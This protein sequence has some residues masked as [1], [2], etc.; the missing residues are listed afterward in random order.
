MNN[1]LLRLLRVRPSWADFLRSV[2]SPV[3]VAQGRIAGVVSSAE[4]WVVAVFRES[5]RASLMRECRPD[6]PVSP[7]DRIR[8]GPRSIRSP[9]CVHDANHSRTRG[10]QSPGHLLTEAFV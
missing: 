2:Y 7:S 4:A 1:R 10:L 8:A 3:D 5:Q 6:S 9:G